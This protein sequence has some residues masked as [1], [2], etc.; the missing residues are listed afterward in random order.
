MAD[1]VSRVAS[2]AMKRGKGVDFTEY[3]RLTG[4]QTIRELLAQIHPCPAISRMAR[5]PG[6]QGLWRDQDIR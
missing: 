4:G 5:N 1:Q 3:R 2:L 6:I